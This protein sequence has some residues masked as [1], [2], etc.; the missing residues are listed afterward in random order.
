MA[1]VVPGNAAN[2]SMQN[3]LM[4]FRRSSMSLSSEEA[5]LEPFLET[6]GLN[7]RLDMV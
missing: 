3:S 1:V 7:V 6:F 4:S 5:A 2:S